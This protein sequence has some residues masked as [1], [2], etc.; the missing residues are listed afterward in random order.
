[1]PLDPETGSAAGELTPFQQTEFDEDDA[2]L[3]PDGRWLAFGCNETG[4]YDIYVRP[5]PG[6]GGKWQV[7]TRGGDFPAWRADGRE[8][9]YVSTEGMVMAVDV[10]GTGGSFKAGEPRPL[11][12][13]PVLTTNVP[14]AVTADGKQFIIVSRAHAESSNSINVIINWNAEI[15]RQ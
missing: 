8:L 7:S 5:F 2:H 12:S 3:S 6:P 15:E 14:Y 10:D 9:Y 13:A 4:R 11:F 1:L